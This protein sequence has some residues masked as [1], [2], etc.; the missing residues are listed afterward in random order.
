MGRKPQTTATE[1]AA[2]TPAAELTP[3]QIARR[4]AKAAA[5]AEAADLRKFAEFIAPF[6]DDDGGI[7]LVKPGATGFDNSETLVTNLQRIYVP[8]SFAVNQVKAERTAEQ[9]QKREQ[10]SLLLATDD[11]KKI[12]A[13]LLAKEQEC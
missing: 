4:A 1:G 5:D 3:R 11:G 7:Y 2:E 8:L 6:T 13:E 9:E 10:L 12:A